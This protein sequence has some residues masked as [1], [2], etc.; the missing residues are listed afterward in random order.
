MTKFEL[1]VEFHIWDLPKEHL[2]R[3]R[4]LKNH[5]LK[6]ESGSEVLLHG[7]LHQ[8][9]ILSHGNDW[10]VIDPKGVI[11]SPIHE[12]WACVEDP[13]YDLKFLSNYFGYSFQDVAEWY[14]V[15]LI[16]AAC[17]Q[18]EDGLDAGKFLTLAK[19]ILPMI[20]PSLI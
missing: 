7:D 16:L 5:L 13:P 9:N 3:A 4:K 15:H 1:P 12:V 6:N 11:G 20:K 18:A 10:V 2:E 17:W 8:E 14:Y 19:F